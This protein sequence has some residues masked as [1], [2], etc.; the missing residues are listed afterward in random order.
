MGNMQVPINLK[1]LWQVPKLSDI[2]LQ[3]FEEEPEPDFDTVSSEKQC[4]CEGS[5]T[6]SKQVLRFTLPC[7]KVLL[8]GGSEYFKTRLLSDLEE[9]A[10]VFPL[11]V[12]DGEAEAAMA[13][14]RSMYEGLPEDATVT[15][16]LLMYKLAD[17]LQ[18]TS[19]R[20]IAEALV[21]LPAEAWSWEDVIMV[22]FRKKTTTLEMVQCAK[23]GKPSMN[24]HKGISMNIRSTGEQF[25]SQS[26]KVLDK[27]HMIA[28]L[29]L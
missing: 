10:T 22:G 16:L 29:H 6:K 25:V 23:H 11:V 20:V 14:I 5:N 26:A 9:G 28:A 2:E 27:P 1:E 13:V 19:M 12:G 18:A 17:R 7:S 15:Q 24:D 8:S 3:I 21:K 4:T